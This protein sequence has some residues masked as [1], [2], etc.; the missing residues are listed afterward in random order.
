MNMYKHV[1]TMFSSLHS[2]LPY[3]VQV[4][5]IPDVA[6]GWRIQHVQ[7]QCRAGSRPAHDCPCQDPTLPR[8]GVPGLLQENQKSKH[9]S[10]GIFT[11]PIRMAKLVYTYQKHMVNSCI[12]KYILL[13]DIMYHHSIVC[14]GAQF[15]D[16]PVP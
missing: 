2:D 13:F 11:P 4:V 15:N 8:E 5:R 10:S 9:H 7:R 1:C 12:Y 6:E 3:P 14:T 16:V